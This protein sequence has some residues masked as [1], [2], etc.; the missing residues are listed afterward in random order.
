MIKRIYHFIVDKKIPTL[1]GAL[2]FFIL[3]NGGAV[4]F[5]I[6]SMSKYLFIDIIPYIDNVLADNSFKDII[7]YLLNHNASIPISIFLL[8]T[9]IYSSSSLYYHFLNIVELITNIP[10]SYSISK[11]LLSLL[12]VPISIIFIFISIILLVI[13]SN[14]NNLFYIFLSL[15]SVIIIYLLNKIA[16]KLKFKRLIKGII[17]TFLYFFIF[18]ILFILFIKINTGFKE[19]YGILSIIIIILFYLYSIIIGLF[20]GMYIN[21]KNIEVSYFFNNE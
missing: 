20:L 18:T 2:C 11:R 1:S 9:S 16:L 17:F 4:L 14:H 8:L 10:I 15:Y 5:L 7:M 21:W 19:I 3:I 12:I 13:L 6:I